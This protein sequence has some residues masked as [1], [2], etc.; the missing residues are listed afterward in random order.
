MKIAV[1]DNPT[2][3]WRTLSKE[4]SPAYIHIHIIFSETRVI[5]L[6]LCH[7]QYG[8]IFIQIFVVGFKNVSFLKYSAYHL[9][10]V[11][12]AS[13]VDYFGTNWKRVCDFL[14]VR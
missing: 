12:R 11:I 1:V 3:V 6:H 8:S 10:K 2:D 7:W 9:F 4:P 13:K 5:G 14:L